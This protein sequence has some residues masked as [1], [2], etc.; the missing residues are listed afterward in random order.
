[1]AQKLRFLLQRIPATRGSRPHGK[2]TLKRRY[3]QRA[4]NTCR[5]AREAHG[6]T[7]R[8][9]QVGIL[10]DSVM[11]AEQILLDSGQAVGSAATPPRRDG[12]RVGF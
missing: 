2:G 4:D 11:L 3:H 10:L 6:A 12:L 9:G 8:G 1:M 7:L 5:S